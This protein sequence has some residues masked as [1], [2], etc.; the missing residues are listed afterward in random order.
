M[1]KLIVVGI[2]TCRPGFEIKLLRNFAPTKDVLG[3]NLDMVLRV[4]VQVCQHERGLVSEVLLDSVLRP[5]N[6]DTRPGVAV[7]RIALVLKENVPSLV[8]PALIL[9]TRYY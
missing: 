2:Y 4:F 3:L 8:L 1:Q 6:D 9:Y 7:H 5:R